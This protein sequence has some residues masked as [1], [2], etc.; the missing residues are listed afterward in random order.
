MTEIAT[1]EPETRKRKLGD[2]VT[3]DLTHEDEE[4]MGKKSIMDSKKQ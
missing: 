4:T 2:I 3:I 1:H